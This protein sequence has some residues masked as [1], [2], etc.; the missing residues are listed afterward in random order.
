ML[1]CMV[2][3]GNKIPI[4]IVTVVYN[5]TGAQRMFAFV[6]APKYADKA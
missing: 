1:T 5:A 4:R 3:N 2:L 6:L